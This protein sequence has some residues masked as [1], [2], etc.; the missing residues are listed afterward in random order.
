MRFHRSLAAAVASALVFAGGNAA[1]SQPPAP[2]PIPIPPEALAPPAPSAPPQATANGA[3]KVA[4][5]DVPA[6]ARRKYQ[7]PTYPPE[8]ALRGIRGIVIVELTISETGAVESAR[9]TRSIPGLDEA[10]VAAVKGWEYEPTRVEGRAVRVLMTQSI[11]FAM[12][13]PELAREPGLPE[14]RSGAAPIMP[15]SMAPPGLAEVALTLNEEGEVMEASVVGGEPPWTDAALRTIRHWRFAAPGSATRFT[16]RVEFR[17]GPPATVALSARAASLPAADRPAEAAAPPPPPVST[18]AAPVATPAGTPPAPTDEPPTEVLAG[19]APGEIPENGASTI[20][21]VTLGERLPDLV[22]GRR[23]TVSPLARLGSVTGE[24]RVRFSVD[25][26]GR[27]TIQ[28]VDGPE[29]LKAAAQGAVETWVFRRTAVE[30]LALVAT[31][32]FSPN[33]ARAHVQHQ[34]L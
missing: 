26:A 23:P 16:V 7:A 14:L 25:L 27:T 22:R 9:V 4:G 19:R 29:L 15:R 5:V 17:A 33:G 20:P 32:T 10:A 6:P 3:P 13:L 28:G 24:V 30:R 8:A 1:W 2:T 21:D 11:T 18:P 12:A 34:P 31:F